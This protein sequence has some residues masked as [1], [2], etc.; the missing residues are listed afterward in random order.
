MFDENSRDMYI[1]ISD[2]ISVL[3]KM[4]TSGVVKIDNHSLQP[5]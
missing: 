2:V 3:C 5:N 4:V 1:V